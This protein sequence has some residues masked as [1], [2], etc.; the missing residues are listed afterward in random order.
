[1]KKTI[2][3][4]IESMLFLSGEPVSPNTVQGIFNVPL[5][6][7]VSLFDE[8]KNEY[9]ERESGIRIRKIGKKYQF[10]T[11]KNNHDYI[12]PVLFPDKEKVLSSAA[13]EVLTIIAYKGPITKPKIDGIRGV[14]SD[15]IVSA[16]IEKDLIEEGGKS[17][18]IGK[19]MLYKTTEKFL[20]YLNIS[21]LD[22]LP[23]F[24]EDDLSVVDSNEE[25]EKTHPDQL[26]ID[27]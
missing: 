22:E 4:V 21:S 24:P 14:K 26:K 16:L 12:K 25:N 9:D 7:V 15:R 20:E 13:L 5:E 1:M 19:P 6:E 2:K 10:I 17:D 18:D 27:L 8:L 23:P 3:S 11:H